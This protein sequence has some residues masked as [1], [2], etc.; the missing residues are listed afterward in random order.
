MQRRQIEITKSTG[1]NT[2][3]IRPQSIISV[4]II[5]DNL[6]YRENISRLINRT[7]GMIADAAFSSCEDAFEK[8]EDG[9]TPQVVLLDIGLPGISG[10]EGIKIIKTLLPKSQIII[11]TIHSDS[12]SVFQAICSGA[13]GYLLKTSPEEKILEGIWDV[14]TGGSPMNPQIARKVLTSFSKLRVASPDYGLT[15]REKKI[16]EMMAEGLTKKEMAN[17][18]TLS[19]HTV[20]ADIRNIYYKL[21]VH[22][23]S[24]A[25]AK[26]LKEGLL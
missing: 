1:E 11:I 19:Y 22:T 6:S 26:A 2:D 21:Q 20:D 15:P 7:K 17:R 23:R 12:N 10:I 9:Y 3:R 25:I 5:E 8:I 14:M 13:S 4:C 24:S 18:A 16:L